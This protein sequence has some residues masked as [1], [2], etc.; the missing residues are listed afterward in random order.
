M[1]TS[2]ATVSWYDPASGVD[3]Y[4]YSSCGAAAKEWGV[5]DV[6]GPAV[7]GARVEAGHHGGGHLVLKKFGA[8]APEKG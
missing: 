4:A 7:E 6:D 8:A 3:L 5:R 1:S 2:A